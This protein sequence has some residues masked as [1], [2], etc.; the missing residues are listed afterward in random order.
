M[1]QVLFIL[2]LLLSSAASFGQ[3]LTIEQY[4]DSV[5]LKVRS[6][7]APL[8]IT[9]GTIA[10]LYDQL[11]DIVD[12]NADKLELAKDS[13]RDEIA[14]VPVLDSNTFLKKTDTSRSG[15]VAT[16]Y[17]VDSLYTTIGT[18][19][20]LVKY[21][22]SSAIFAT[23]YQ[24]DTAKQNIRSGI[25]TPSLQQV[26][27][28]GSTSTEIVEVAALKVDS[29]GQQSGSGNGGYGVLVERQAYYD[30]PLIVD[31]L[32]NSARGFKEG[33]T[34]TILN[35]NAGYASF[36]AQTNI[37]SD[38]VGN[39]EH[40]VCFQARGIFNYPSGSTL[41]GMFG[42]WS[43]LSPRRATVTNVHDFYAES[44]A[45][46]ATP[47]TVENKFGFYAADF[48]G[49][50][51]NTFGFYSAGAT[52]KNYFAGSVGIND[53][54]T[55]AR[56]QVDGTVLIKDTLTATG[57]VKLQGVTGGTE[58][59]ALALN[60]NDVLMKVPLPSVSNLFANGGN[61]F[62]NTA[63]LGTNDANHLDI[64][65]NNTVRGRIGSTGNWMIG[66]TT[67]AGYKLDVNGS[68]MFRGAPAIFQT[69]ASDR[70]ILKSA[71]SSFTFVVGNST[72]ADQPYGVQSIIIN[73]A[74]FSSVMSGAR[75][76]LIGYQSAASLNTGGRNT[77][78]GSEAGR[79]ST[80]GGYNT[81]I[82]NA[83]GS[84]IT[85]GNN[86]V[87]LG[88]FAG[89][90]YETSS[91]NVF[92]SD[93]AGNLRVRIPS[94]GEVILSTIPTVTTYDSVLVTENGGIKKILFKVSASATLDFPSTASNENSDLT[95][96][97]P[98][99]AVGDPV[100]IGHALTAQGTF[101][102]TVSASDVVTIRFHN[103]AAGVYDP[104]SGA[105]KVY[106]WK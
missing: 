13:L 45:F 65:T 38:T 12:T 49:D 59:S 97:V 22:D 15:I 50:A 99:A 34:L 62:G 93:G 44:I 32:G 84:A 10:N 94:T 61:S 39:L 9:K 98:G 6:A 96:A 100:S 35:A 72:T 78:I 17:Y 40:T 86:N 31:W 60:A 83:A 95:I 16:Y 77:H 42:F 67:D 81:F 52:D 46:S 63:T 5:D 103:T 79:S 66:T 105:F 106:V 56:L 1:R 71:S 51:T 43:E 102:G 18:H 80:T 28:V 70:I 87:V 26:T 48:A 24:L 89:T 29:F 25:T 55:S 53:T 23:Q 69:S 74:G 88:G 11:A 91:N 41:N 2:V 14:A 27:E 20:S 37:F 82:G 76:T 68:V 85:T 90:G 19:D 64:E 30:P 73:P 47:A 58:D 33:S 75:N 57:V 54:P 104:P 7:T 21:S 101:E 8:S 4:K 3:V 36:D 92:I